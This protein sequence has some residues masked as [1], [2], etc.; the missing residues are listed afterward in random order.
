MSWGKI[1]P[2]Q[3][4]D[5]VVCYTDTTIALPLLTAYI[6]ERAPARP[7]KRLGDRRAE[8]L[9]QLQDQY[10]TRGRLSGAPTTQRDHRGPDT[11]P[12]GTPEGLKPF[13][14]SLGKTGGLSG[15]PFLNPTGTVKMDVGFG[16]RSRGPVTWLKRR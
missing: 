13:G 7:L 15:S 1:D 6:L 3:L 16:N 2:D 8:L 14:R 5:T 10:A 12:C 9:G 11:W 4:P